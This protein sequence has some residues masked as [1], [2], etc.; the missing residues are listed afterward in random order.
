MIDALRSEDIINKVGGRFK[1]TA[2]LQRRAVELMEGAKPLIEKK[3]DMT[4]LEIAIQEVLEDKI[5]IDYD[6]SD[7]LPPEEL[8]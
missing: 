1:L 6:N 5:R 2:L 3:K 4:N 8:K 7:V